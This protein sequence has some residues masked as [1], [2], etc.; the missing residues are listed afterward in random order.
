MFIVSVGR[1]VETPFRA[2][3]LVQLFCMYSWYPDWCMCET[4][5]LA[6]AFWGGNQVRNESETVEE[7]Y[8]IS[9]C[10]GKIH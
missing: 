8:I 5:V 1:L 6:I 4:S 7:K 3:A 9:P 2:L 10:V